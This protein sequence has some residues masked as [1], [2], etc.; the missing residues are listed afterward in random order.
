M[1]VAR[2]GVFLVMKQMFGFNSTSMD[3]RIC[4]WLQ[5][6]RSVRLDKPAC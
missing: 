2:H 3:L 1:P 4:C 6:V 5:K